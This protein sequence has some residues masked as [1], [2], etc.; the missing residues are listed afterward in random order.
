VAMIIVQ[1]EDSLG[2]RSEGS[3]LH[4]II[5]YSKKIFYEKKKIR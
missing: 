5:F 2:Q 1:F 3:N 4:P